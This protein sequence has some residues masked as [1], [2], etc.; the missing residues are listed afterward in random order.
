MTGWT[1]CFPSLFPCPWHWLGRCSVHRDVQ[2]GGHSWLTGTAA[3]APGDQLV[4]PFV[5]MTAPPVLLLFD[6]SC[7]HAALLL[8]PEL[9]PDGPL[10]PPAVTPGSG[11]A[12]RAARQLTPSLVLLF[13]LGLW[14]CWR[15]WA[16]N[17]SHQG[18]FLGSVL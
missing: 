5:K 7:F 2:E 12:S 4:H 8:S 18:T 6:S 16:V 11:L 9:C 15:L 3:Q 14:T 10:V 17:P 1:S 13:L